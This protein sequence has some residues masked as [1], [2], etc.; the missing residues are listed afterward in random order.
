MLYELINTSREAQSIQFYGKES[1][2]GQIS[3]RE[4]Q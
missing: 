1:E 2:T 4:F 3:V